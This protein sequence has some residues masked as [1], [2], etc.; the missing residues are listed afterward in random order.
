MRIRSARPDDV[1]ALFEL[2]EELAEYEALTDA[3][4]GDTHLLSAA[5]F[6]HE[7]AEALV[8]EVAGGTVGY[9]IF[10]TTFSTFECRPGLWVEDLFV[11]EDRRGQGIGRALLADI[12]GIAVDRGCARLEWSA[13][14]WNESALRFY[15]G[16]GA[17]RLE[18]WQA[19]RLEGDQLK[20]LGGR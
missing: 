19:L 9:A 8:A 1:P 2:I 5:L 18:Q 20:M 10:F 17:D 7:T 4:Q 6:E 14:G 13:L 12:A 11:K 15:K 3:V 16:L